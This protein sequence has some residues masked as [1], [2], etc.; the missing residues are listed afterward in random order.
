MKVKASVFYALMVIVG[1]GSITAMIV[2]LNISGYE[3]KC[4]LMGG[5]AVLLFSVIL[6]AFGYYRR[7]RVC[8]DKTKNETKEVALTKILISGD[9]E[10]L[11]A[12]CAD[13]TVID[14]SLK[15]I[16]IEDSDDKNLILVINEFII[17]YRYQS[18]FVAWPAEPETEQFYKLRVPYEMR[19]IIENLKEEVM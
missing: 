15:R 7:E 11:K 4:W 1:L 16:R 9:K 13:G 10:T 18:L 6:F 2:G 12:Y 5:M 3:G 8:I 19:I 14:M 17:Y